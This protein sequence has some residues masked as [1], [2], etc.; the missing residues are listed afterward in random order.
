M[1]I[2]DT[3]PCRPSPLSSDQW[4]APSAPSRPCAAVPESRGS[5]CSSAAWECATRRFLPGSPSP[6]HDSRC[7]APAGTDPS[8]HG[9]RRHGA[10]LQIHQPFSGKANHLAQKVRVRVFSTRSR[11]LIPPVRV[12]FQWAQHRL[13]VHPPRVNRG[14][15]P[16]GLF[17][18]SSSTSS[19]KF[20]DGRSAGFRLT[21]RPGVAR[22][23]PLRV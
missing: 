20:V 15:R 12:W 23:K 14:T 9:P 19:T 7:A 3:S 2:A 8:R 21:C 10:D 4:R 17:A 1:I 13:G 22:T 11:R 18:H 16:T 5:R 6:G